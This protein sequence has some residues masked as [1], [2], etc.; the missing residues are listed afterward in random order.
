MPET[1][2]HVLYIAKVTWGLALKAW[3]IGIIG[4][5]CI[6]KIISCCHIVITTKSLSAT[7]T[8]RFIYRN[9]KQLHHLNPVI[10]VGPF[11]YGGSHQ[12]SGG[13]CMCTTHACLEIRKCAT[14]DELKRWCQCRKWQA[15]PY[16]KTLKYSTAEPHLHLYNIISQIYQCK[17]ILWLKFQQNPKKCF[18]RYNLLQFQI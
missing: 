4:H 16:Q 18:C 8:E 13:S 17:Q 6:S 2:V 1:C 5:F 10:R 12:H 3:I 14:K 11:M 9:R 15:L 7:Q